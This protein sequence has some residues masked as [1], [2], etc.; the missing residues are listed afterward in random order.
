[1][2]FASIDF[3]TANYS[4]ASICAAGLAVI[5]DGNF[6]SRRIGLSVHRRVADGSVKTSLR[7]T[8]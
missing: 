7:F 5:E 4:D 8:A 3:E 2:T 6:A 1:M